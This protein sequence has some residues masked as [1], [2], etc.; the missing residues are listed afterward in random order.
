M[1]FVHY[2][3][4]VSPHQ[5]PLAREIAKRVGVDE[6]RYVYVERVLSD[7]KA[8]GWTDENDSWIVAA[9]EGP[10]SLTE[11]GENLLTGI[12]D[13]A[14]F[15]R[16]AARGLKTF[17]QS[18]RWFKPIN[19]G[20][21][22]LPGCL[23]LLSPSYFKMARAFV[24]WLAADPNARCLAIG[25][26]AERD[27]RLLFCLFGHKAAD[28]IVPWGYFV[29]PSEFPNPTRPSSPVLK[30][31]WVGRLLAWKRVD[32]IVWAMRLVPNASLTIVGEGPEK[33]RLMQLAQGFNVHFLGSQPIGKIREIMRS[34][35]V[36][37]LASNSQE[38]WGAALSEALEEGM[39]A[40][41]TFEAGA[42][43]AMLPQGNLFHAGDYKTLGKIL[44]GR[45]ADVD[46][47]A[48]TAQCAADKLVRFAQRRMVMVQYGE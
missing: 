34:H 31:L 23:R 10:R 43:A 32:T 38:G 15:Q 22:S 30:I 27:F 18:E 37:V 45:I 2:A 20:G 29:E 44:S 13:V 21:L 41:G 4:C 36:Y 39:R 42:S 3:N 17:Y 11:E 28:R 8:M 40:A 35:D 6:F 47:K 14:L 5:L 9:S 48:W 1:K 16:R 7:R 24:R 46:F 25:P 19:F 33:A 12:R 26:W